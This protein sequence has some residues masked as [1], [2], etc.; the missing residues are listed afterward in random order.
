MILLV[1]GARYDL[2]DRLDKIG[3]KAGL[4]LTFSNR[5]NQGWSQ[6]AFFAWISGSSR[7]IFV[8]CKGNNKNPKHGRKP[9]TA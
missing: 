5:Q 9:E 7:R 3:V 4:N 2:C 1:L 8:L 6:S